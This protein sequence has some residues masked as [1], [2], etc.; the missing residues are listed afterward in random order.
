MTSQ[1]TLFDLIGTLARKRYAMAE[2][3][4]ARLGLNHSEARLLHALHK[5]GGKGSQEQ[6]T[7]QVQIDRTNVGRA[8]KSL[9]AKQLIHR[10]RDESDKRSNL[11]SITARGELLV[12]E[13]GLIGQEMA[14]ALFSSLTESE[15]AAATRILSKVADLEVDR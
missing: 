8:L 15:V 3:R 9:E 2:R 12:G 6:M 7:S 1:R 10:L 4:F 11:V 13:I 5:M 14:Q